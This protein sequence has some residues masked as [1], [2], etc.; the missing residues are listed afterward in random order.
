MLTNLL[1]GLRDLRAPLAAGYLWLAA[2]WL[3]FAPQLPTS[4]DDA[5]GVL[6]DIYRVAHTSQPIAVAAGLTFAAYMVGILSTGLLV[7][8]MRF[9]VKLP[10]YILYIPLIFLV[11][12]SGV[13]AERWPTVESKLDN[14]FAASRIAKWRFQRS[15][16]ISIRADRL[17]L[18]RMSNKILADEDYR[19]LFLARLKERLEDIVSHNSMPPGSLGLRRLQFVRDLLDNPSV[20]DGEKA[21]EILERLSKY[22]NEGYLEAAEAQCFP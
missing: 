13:L 4:V 5:Q 16:S 1:P 3:Y 22:L 7:V 21:K 12:L 9:I 20:D 10:I 17:A 14:F 8:P 15:K 11:Y 2:G 19:G 18:R 6:K